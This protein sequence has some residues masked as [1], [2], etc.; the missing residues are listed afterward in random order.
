LEAETPVEAPVEPCS[1][2]IFAATDV[3]VTEAST[4]IMWPHL[5][6]FIRTVRP[7]TLSSAIWYFALQFSQRN[8]IR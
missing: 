1:C 7:A 2:G 6:H 5:R 4:S 8:F 3:S